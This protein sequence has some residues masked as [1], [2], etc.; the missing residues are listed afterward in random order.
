MQDMIEKWAGEPLELTEMRGIRRFSDGARM[1]PHVDR[2]DTHAVSLQIIIDMGGMRQPWY[3][4]IFDHGD[5]LHE[6]N[7]PK[8]EAIM[9]ESS[10]C[11]HGRI[12]P[13]DGDYFVML[14]A[15]YR[16]IR[17]PH[18]FLNQHNTPRRTPPPVKDLGNCHSNGTHVMCPKSPVAV[19]Y[20]SPQLFKPRSP[21]EI[22]E[23]WLDGDYEVMLRKEF[24]HSSY[25]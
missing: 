12:Q 13:L 22:Y 18:W 23:H 6:L 1:L 11:L 7:Q 9:Y 19:P 15:H 8:G 16:P 5:R 3:Q 14:S 10:R 24:E 2:E 25:M 20:L 21:D 4:Q 17:N